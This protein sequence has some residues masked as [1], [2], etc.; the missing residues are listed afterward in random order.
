MYCQNC[1]K[2]LRC[3]GFISICLLQIL[4]SELLNHHGYRTS[5]TN[6]KLV[7]VSV[8]HFSPNRQILSQTT[9]REESRGWWDQKSSK[10]QKDAFSSSRHPSE[11]LNLEFLLSWGCSLC[12][13]CWQEE[14]HNDK[15]DRDVYLWLSVMIQ[16]VECQWIQSHTHSLWQNIKL[17]Q[18]LRKFLWAAQIWIL[19]RI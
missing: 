12:Y 8:T 7:S 2:I 9:G 6:L 15:Q 17:K 1:T 10:L 16:D 18:A 4:N 19:T 13:L 11:T 14:C 5:T 3:K